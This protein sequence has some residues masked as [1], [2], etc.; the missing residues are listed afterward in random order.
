M[1]RLDKAKALVD[2]LPDEQVEAMVEAYDTIAAAWAFA[3]WPPE[4]QRE[5][6]RKAAV[7]AG[8]PTA[9]SNVIAFSAADLLQ[10]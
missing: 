7:Y 4:I 3:N 9:T 6:A 1:N 2:A 10:N 5:A 8:I